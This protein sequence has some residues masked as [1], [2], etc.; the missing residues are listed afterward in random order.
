MD[1][2]LEKLAMKDLT[3]NW[4]KDEKWEDYAYEAT[5]RLVEAIIEKEGVDPDDIDE[6]DVYHLL[7][8]TWTDF[9]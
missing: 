7:L 3:E 5:D 1:K 8:D 2:E 9:L 6:Q 4:T